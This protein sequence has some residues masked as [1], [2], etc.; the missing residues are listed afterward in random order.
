MT[1]EQRRLCRDLM[2]EPSGKRRVSKED[3]VSRFPS[4]LQQDKLAF[5]LLDDAQRTQN[6]EELQCALIVGFTFGFC[7]QHK[8]ILVDLANAGWHHSHEDIV[9]ALENWPSGETVDALF[10]ATQRVPKYLEF[11]DNRALAVKAIWAIGKVPGALAEARLVELSRSH[12]S[13]LRMN[14]MKQLERRHREP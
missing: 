14:A 11:D 8:D 2:I 7:V 10:Q 4:A 12:D 13:V 1:P 6:A 3:F 9:S 5:D